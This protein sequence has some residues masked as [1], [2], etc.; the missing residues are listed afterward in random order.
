MGAEERD[1]VGQLA[2]RAAHS[3]ASPC[4]VE[5]VA[6]LDLEVRDPGAQ[7]LRAGA[8]Q[9]ASRS[10]WIAR[11]ARRARPWSRIPPAAYGAPAIRAA[12]SSAAVAGEDQVGVAVDEP[13]D[14]A[15]AGGVE[16][17]VGGG[18]RAARSRPPRSSSNTSAASRTTPSGPSPSAGSLVTSRPMLS[19]ASVLTDRP[20]RSRRASSRATSSVRWRAVADDEL[21]ADDHVA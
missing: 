3:R 10:S 17:L 21:A 8:R 15:A 6:R 20:R 11:R 7:R 12:N 16:P 14:H 1:V 4:D 13:R 2:R 18:A 5:R 19:I 9:R